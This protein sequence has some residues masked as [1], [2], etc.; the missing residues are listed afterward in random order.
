LARSWPDLG[1]LYRAVRLIEFFEAFIQH[2]GRKVF[3]VPENLP[4]HMPNHLPDHL[5][6]NLAW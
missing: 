5:L 3:L 4:D 1:L 2:A 6:D